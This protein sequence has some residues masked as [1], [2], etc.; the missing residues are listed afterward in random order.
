[1]LRTRVQKLVVVPALGIAAVLALS[2]CSSL[3]S[4]Q[5]AQRFVT[6]LLESD[7]A[8]ASRLSSEKITEDD[9]RRLRQMIC[10]DERVRQVDAV[11]VVPSLQ[12]DSA[13]MYVVSAVKA[14]PVVDGR[15]LNERGVV[16]AL[17]H[18]PSGW[19]VLLPAG[20]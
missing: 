5:T 12:T 7:V 14:K 16:L 19:T 4:E 8:A 6:A 3:T 18:G 2:A 9:A 17:N 15:D 10:G 1:M 11:T 13:A 20:E